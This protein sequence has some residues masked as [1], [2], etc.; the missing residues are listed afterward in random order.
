MF[1]AKLSGFLSHR[2]R[3]SAVKQ[4]APPRRSILVSLAGIFFLWLALFATTFATAQIPVFIN[5][6]HYDN[7]GTD[8]GEA[9]EI[10]GPAGTDLTGWSIVLYNGIPTS[11]STYDTDALSG[12]IPELGSGFGVVVLNYAVNGIQNGNPDGIALVNASSTVVQ[13]L[14]Y[15]GVFTAANGPAAGMTS[16]D[17]GVSE[18]G[19]TPVGHSLQLG[20]IGSNYEDFTWNSA[21]ANTFGIFHTG[22]TF[23]VPVVANAGLNKTICAGSSTTI[24]A[25]PAASG[26][27]GGP[28]TFSWSPSDGLNQTDTANPTAS[29]A[30][31]TT[32]T[33]TVTEPG[34]GLT[35]TDEVTV[36]V[37]LLPTATV[38]GDA[39]ICAGESATISAALTG[40][41]PWSLT[42]SDGFS[43]N[44]VA[45]SSATRMVSP[46]STT[47]YTVTTVIDDNGC[48]NTGA[49]SAMITV[50]PLPTATVSGDATICDGESATISA[51]LTGASPWNLTW[52]DGVTQNGVTSSP[53]MRVVS[54]SSTTVYSVTTVTDDNDCSDSGTGDATITV[55]A[56]ATVVFNPVG[57]FCVND[58]PEDLSS[59]VSS[60]GGAFSGNGVSGNMFDPGDAGV[61]THTITYTVSGAC[62]GSASRD[63]V[64][65]PLPNATFNP[66]GPFDVSDPPFDLSGSVLP[67]GGTFSGPGISGTMFN[68]SSAGVGTHTLMYS[69]TDGN[70]CTKSSS[71][72]VPVNGPSV[73][74]GFVFVVDKFINLEKHGASAGD[75]HSNHD[76]QFKTGKPSTYS[77]NLTAVGEVTIHTK[78]TVNGSIKAGDEV[79]V[80]RKAMVNGTIDENYPVAE[81]PLPNPA[82]PAEGNDYAV[83]INGTLS[84]PPGSYGNVMVGKNATLQLGHNGISGEYFFNMLQ[85]NQKSVLAID[86][87]QGE[88]EINVVRKLDFD[89][90]VK[91]VISSGDDDS[92]EVTFTTLQKSRLTIGD[93]ARV[94]GEII[95]ADAAVTLAKNSRFKGTLW[96]KEIIVRQ[97]AVFLPHGAS[98]ILPARVDDSDEIEDI[99]EQITEAASLRIT[100]YALAQNYPNPFNPSTTIKFAMPE[101]GHVTLRIYA[102]TGQLVQTLVDGEMNAGRHNVSWNGRDQ[103]G[104]AVSSGIY[105]YQ[106]VAQKA[107]GEAAFTQTRRMIL[108]K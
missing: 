100:D 27:A 58:S 84:L 59:A 85:T 15:G 65:H 46:S 38:S 5:E 92:D 78:N 16:A 54:P 105:F 8:A 69:F 29:P 40:A 61:G 101:A 56:T 3:G 42:W 52:S 26:G 106:L 98:T 60:A 107:D 7:T 45:T 66:V 79:N 51:A 74:A 96:A 4:G 87:T 71:Q 90:Q 24:G 1:Y 63:I 67:S 47:A 77:G 18:G 68:P 49:G 73:P 13:F 39:T 88:V 95:A 11:L 12:T 80:N 75:I 64:V 81:I 83:P 17:I 19:S 9:I 32:Y 21:A 70:S 10:A 91:V 93:K 108:L 53:A 36:T 20:G 37:N 94:L 72:Q 82:F 34:T 2:M 62:G 55:N 104:A 33:L 14:S 28:Y 41:A 25:M 57:P 31:P 89:K 6:I 44:G 35:D 23:A 102:I 99:E 76:I 103:A 50:N 30:T 97:G 22:Q 48:S 86:V 43:Q